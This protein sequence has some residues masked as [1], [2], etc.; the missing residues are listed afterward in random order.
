MKS[1]NVFIKNNELVLIEESFSVKAL[2][3]Q[4]FWLVYYKMWN[5]V[6]IF[7]LLYFSCMLFL[8]LHIIDINLML[9]IDVILSLIIGAFAKTWLIAT[10]KNY[11]FDLKAVIV[12]KNAEEAKLKFFEKN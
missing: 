10:L 5:Y 11:G 6:A 2:I 8:K 9:K 1:F 7:V 3:F 4:V 12:A